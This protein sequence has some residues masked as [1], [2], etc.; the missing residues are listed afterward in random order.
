MSYLVNL[1]VEGRSVVVVGGGAV[2]ARKVAALVDAKARVTVVAPRVCEALDALERSGEVRVERRAYAPGDVSGAFVVVAA[3][4]DEEVNRQVAGDAR[5]AR[6]L[7]N[8]VDR[9]ALCAFTVP[10][11]VR[12]GDLTLA[13]ATGGRC[14]SLARAI[15]EQLERQFGPEY[16]E[17][18]ARLGEL[19]RRLIAEGWESPR[20]HRAISALVDAGLVQAIASGDE[21]RAASLL[22]GPFGDDDDR[23][24]G[25]RH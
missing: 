25:A 13:V 23:P 22:A 1:V 21:A 5:A 4:D 7:V 12:R 24:G 16:A 10:A 3:T 18:V 20:I 11:V 6:A 8:V 2:A 15:R 14:P 9:P 19:R 17:A